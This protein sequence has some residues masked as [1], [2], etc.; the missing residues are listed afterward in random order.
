LPGKPGSDQPVVGDLPDP[1]DRWNISMHVLPPG[2][3]AGGQPRRTKNAMQFLGF[4]EGRLCEAGAKGCN[5]GAAISSAGFETLDALD[6]QLAKCAANAP[7]PLRFTLR[8]FTSTSEFT[9]SVLRTDG[10]AVRERHPDS[11]AMNL[12][13]ADRRAVV[14]AASL[15]RSMA[16]NANQG[17]K[18]TILWNAELDRRDKPAVAQ[19]L[20][21]MRKRAYIDR[22][23]TSSGTTPVGEYDREAGSRNRR[24]DIDFQS[25]GTCDMA[26]LDEAILD[27]A[28]REMQIAA[29]SG[30]PGS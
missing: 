7:E 21:A 3:D 19:R 20:A 11:D 15:R 13:L 25:M 5:D 12:D 2:N 26:D 29:T 4:S 8:G 6:R 16:L 14:I 9:Q 17:A 22:G 24:V 18:A 30:S 27:G 1:D 28:P 10:S 23:R